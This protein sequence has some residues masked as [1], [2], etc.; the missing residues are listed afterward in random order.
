MGRVI[1]S[2]INSLLDK[3]DDPKK[4]LDLTI[5]EMGE[6]IRGAKR[7]IVEALGTQK[8]LTRKLDEFDAQVAK[9]EKRA[10][11]ALTSEDEDLAREALKHKRRIIAERDRAEAA[12]SE[13]R[14]VV[15]TMKREME[16]MATKLGELSARKNT[17]AGELERAKQG[18]GPEALGASGGVGG[19]SFAE[20]RRMEAKI[21]VQRAE[22]E[23]LSE[24]DAVLNDGLS[25]AALEAK[26]AQLEGRVIDGKGGE[27]DDE[28]AALKK[29]L[30]IG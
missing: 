1:S 29:K 22:G 20:F 25:E 5:D 24:I 9:W 2:N 10:E 7:E 13:Q 21:D 12:R 6:S 19:G 11:L 30:R 15:L 4:S 8:V 28:I 17:I 27:I 23:A 26:F 18:G 16:R 14:G 3:A